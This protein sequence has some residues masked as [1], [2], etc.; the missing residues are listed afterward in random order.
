MTKA[1]PKFL[2]KTLKDSIGKLKNM[3]FATSDVANIHI[4]FEAEWDER[5]IVSQRRTYRHRESVQ[6]HDILN[7]CNRYGEWM[8]A[9]QSND[10]SLA[11][12]IA[13]ECIEEYQ[14]YFDDIARD[15]GDI[16]DEE[17]YDEDF[18]E[19]IDSCNN[20]FMRGTSQ[21]HS[22]RSEWEKFSRV[23][24]T[25]GEAWYLPAL[26][27]IFG[28]RATPLTD[29]QQYIWLNNESESEESS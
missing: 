9:M 20:T 29:Q 18:D 26:K 6:L 23:T 4:T 7:Y 21:P 22:I 3:I 24:D 17:N 27:W 10:K 11:M 5:W 15:Y 1:I 2:H 16:V 28:L 14:D 12:Q 19:V 8:Q 25:S 13:D